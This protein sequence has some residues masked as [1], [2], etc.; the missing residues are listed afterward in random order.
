MLHVYLGKLAFA[1]P[2]PPTAQANVYL[3]MWER[4]LFNDD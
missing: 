3:N 2:P 4:G 1:V